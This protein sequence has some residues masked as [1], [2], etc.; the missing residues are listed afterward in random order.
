MTSHKLKSFNFTKKIIIYK[1]ILIYKKEFILLYIHN[2]IHIY[3][4][5]VIETKTLLARYSRSLAP[6]SDQIL[7]S[8]FTF[9][10]PP[11]LS[12]NKVN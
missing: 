11:Q 10:K 3:N 1:L 8:C 12:E 6:P 2:N 5:K 9:L 4:K 7:M